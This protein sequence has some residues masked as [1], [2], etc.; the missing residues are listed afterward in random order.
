VHWA[1]AASRLGQPDNT[2]ATYGTVAAVQGSQVQVHV[3]SGTTLVT[4][5]ETHVFNRTSSNSSMTH[6]D[7]GFD[8]TV[9]G[10]PAVSVGST[11]SFTYT[12]DETQGT[13]FAVA[14]SRIK[15]A[16]SV[17]VAMVVSIV[18]GLVLGVVGVILLIVW[19]VS[20]RRNRQPT[21]PMYSPPPSYWPPHP[22]QQ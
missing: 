8:A 7:G 16:G 14:P 9:S 2:S 17:P 20:L 22:Q 19:L 12:N 18:V 3:S 1:V 15:A 13:Y 10:A 5:T 6:V 11:L 4:R 21:P